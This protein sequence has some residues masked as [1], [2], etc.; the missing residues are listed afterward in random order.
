MPPGPLSPTT[1]TFGSAIE[2]LHHLSPLSRP[3]RMARL[4]RYALGHSGTPHL[5]ALQR[6]LDEHGHGRLALHMA[7]AARDLDLIAP[8]LAGPDP[9]LR[10]AALRAVRTLPVPDEAVRPLLT[11]ASAGLRRALYRTLFTARR[12]TLADSLLDRVRAEFGDQDAAALLPACTPDTVTRRLPDLAHAVSSWR[13]LARRHPDTLA[14]H[15]A[16]RI[17]DEFTWWPHRRAL[18]ALDEIRPGRVL[19]M[20]E[21]SSL[22]NRNL[23]VPRARR[24]DRTDTLDPHHGAPLGPRLNRELWR[25]M[26]RNPGTARCVLR[27]LPPE[28]AAE[29]IE[30]AIER[31]GDRSPEPLFPFLD[32][33]PPARAE[34]IARN[35]LRRFAVFQRTNSRCLD[36]HRDLDAIVHLPYAEAAPLLSEAASAGD[37]ERRARGLARLMEATARTGDPELLATVLGERVDRHGADRDPVRRALLR[38]LVPM[39]PTLLSPCLDALHRLVRDTLR[40]RDT[41]ATTRRALR[42]LVARL[43]R[44]PR[45]RLDPAVQDWGVETYARLVERFGARGWG[46]PDRARHNRPWWARNP[47]SVWWRGTEPAGHHHGPEPRLDQILPPGAETML[48]ERLAP[49][50]RALRRRDPEALIALAGELGR[51]GRALAPHLREIV[52]DDPAHGTAARAAAL[53]LSGPERADRALGLFEGD[54]RTARVPRVW[55][56]LT[57]HHG[58]DTLDRALDAV[59]GHPDS[60]EPT[61]GP[62]S[63]DGSSSHEWENRWRTAG[64]DPVW[65]P[66]VERVLARDWPESLRARLTTHLR[67]V[68]VDPVSTVEEREAALRSLCALPGGEAHLAVHLAGDDVLLREAT[69]SALGRSADPAG[70]LERVISNADGP[71]SRAAGP[72]M[73]RCAR[74][75]PPSRLGSSLARALEGPVKVTVRKSAA[76]LLAAHRPEE[77]VPSLTRVLRREAEHRDVTAAVAA[78]LLRCADDPRAL[79]ALAERVPALASEEIQVALL[80]VDPDLLAPAVRA[81]A[82]RILNTLP[83]P[84]RGHWRMAGWWARWD[85]WGEQTIDD[86]VDA[87]CDL[88][89]PLTRSMAA[90]RRHLDTGRGVDRIA[91]ALGRLLDQVPPAARGIPPRRTGPERWESAHRRV[92]ELAGLMNTLLERTDAGH[93]IGEDQ[94]DRCLE[95]LRGR[96]EYRSETVR[97]LQTD[98]NRRLREQDDPS[99]ATV[100]DH[101]SDVAGVLALGGVA[102]PRH[103]DRHVDGIVP[104]YGNGGL[105]N[106][107]SAAVVRGLLAVAAADPGE[108]GRVVGALALVM[109]E[110][111]GGETGWADPWPELL[112]AVGAVGH[113][114]LLLHAWHLAMG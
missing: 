7:T 78:A 30:R 31:L 38:S 86:V 61:D 1:P 49:G 11:D 58:P 100:V 12:T 32:L 103:M 43:L 99:A 51:R 79:S 71:R 39:E 2:L 42:D 60:E 4:A 35:A 41:S 89:R 52:L 26:R 27:S 13:R 17:T 101:L 112:T 113:E 107:T 19:G 110:R 23:R 82:A 48:L 14:D 70:T 77:A 91:E 67:A 68:V 29:R 40:S 22:R 44:H 15:L 74:W 83:A 6:E 109:V 36:A 46:D 21:N 50:L 84:E 85:L 98:L 106:E 80:G 16:E 92:Q 47:R 94:R 37:P 95:L 66:R 59:L 90:L 111:C 69:M 20:L 9:E 18:A 64:D 34:E 45:T 105:P 104:R 54:P 62:R 73:S 33:L 55:E 25:A 56:T 5:T 28:R 75:T 93:M 10:R 63:A 57:L 24:L 114:D 108:H 81:P 96:V 76:R 97:L 3:D 53:Y 88:D 8:H 72:V 102:G 87:L 65:V